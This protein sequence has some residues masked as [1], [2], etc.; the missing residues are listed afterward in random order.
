M[1]K[2][3]IIIKPERLKNLKEIL[4]ESNANGLII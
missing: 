1:K 2:S 4:N 3:E